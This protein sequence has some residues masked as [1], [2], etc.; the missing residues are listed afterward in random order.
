MDRAD[1]IIVS[2]AFTIFAIVIRLEMAWWRRRGIEK[3]DLHDSL[4]NYSL[5]AMQFL[6]GVIGKGLFIIAGLEWLRER[7]PRLVG[8]SWWHWLVLFLGV[9]LGYFIFHWASHRIRFL[10]AIHEAHHS[11][12][13]M[14]FSVALRQPPLEPLIDWLFFI[15]LAWIGFPAKAILTMYAFNLFYQFFIHTE[16]IGR[17]PGWLEWFLNTPSHHRAHHGT[18]TQYL[19]RNF[20]GTLIVWDR[21]FG[22]FTPEVERVRYGVLHP[23]TSRNPFFVGFHLWRDIIRDVAASR[24]WRE[25]L[26]YLLG[27]A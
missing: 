1:W 4:A 20:G 10:W 15:G 11:S 24:S 23:V 8:E 13:L 6:C 22:T 7:G 5:V 19:D 2:V 14:N 12:E 21:L 27:R 26:G 18:N 16:M 25:R 17:L 9:D 3:Y